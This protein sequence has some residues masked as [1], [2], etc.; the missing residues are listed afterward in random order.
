MLCTS[1]FNSPAQ[2]LTLDLEISHEFFS[3]RFKQIFLNYLFSGRNN[4]WP[5]LLFRCDSSSRLLKPNKRKN[6]QKKPQT[7]SLKN[8]NRHGSTNIIPEKRNNFQWISNCIKKLIDKCAKLIFSLFSSTIEL[9]GVSDRILWP[10]DRPL[11]NRF[12]PSDAHS[13]K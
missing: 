3:A 11:L 10:L 8:E 4:F 7:A 9:N 5:F 2:T 6:I 12:N 13:T 1:S